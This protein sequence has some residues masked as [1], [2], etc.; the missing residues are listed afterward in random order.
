[1]DLKNLVEKKVSF[2]EF[3]EESRHSVGELMNIPKPNFLTSS[4]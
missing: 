1:M 4:S 3:G 2:Q